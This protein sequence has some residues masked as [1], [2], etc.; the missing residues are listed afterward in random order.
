[1]R[2]RTILNSFST[3][4]L[5]LLKT[6]TFNKKKT[7]DMYVKDFTYDSISRAKHK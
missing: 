2:R 6:Y 7:H 5:K 4:F 1:M 3:S